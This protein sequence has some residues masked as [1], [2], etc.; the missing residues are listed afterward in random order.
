MNVTFAS[1]DEYKRKTI[2]EKLIQLIDSPIDISPIVIDGNWG[3]GKTEFSLKLQN[4][5]SDEH[6]QK[7]VIYI[8]AFKEDHCEDPLLSVTAAIANALPKKKQDALIKKAI[9]ALKFT[10]TTALKAG[11]NWVLK[12]ETETLAEDFQKAL[13]DTSNAAVD[14]AMEAL[15]KGHME[16]EKNISALKEKIRELAA[17]SQIIIIVDELDRCR[18]DFSIDMLEKI[19]HIFDIENVVFILITNLNQLKAAVNHIYGQSVNSQ[20]YLDKFIKYT[21]ALPETVKDY[22]NNFVHTSLAHWD[23]LAKNSLEVTESCML[24]KSQIEELLCIRPLSLRETET[25]FRYFSI[26]QKISEEKINKQKLYIWNLTALAAIYMYCFGDKSAIQNFPS[27]ASVQSLAKTMRIESIFSDE[28][29]IH[30]IPH[31]VFAFYGLCTQTEGIP[32]QWL[33][34]NEKYIPDLNLHLES[35]TERSLFRY[36]FIR[37]IKNTFSAFSLI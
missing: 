1:R 37:T 36:S 27:K 35:L 20:A 16:S 24:M 18:P 14:G 2:A 12:Q 4:L 25:F 30:N 29:E 31:F 6:P 8:D 11:I 17:E 34:I 9:P 33:G 21:L 7:K 3:T 22:T 15:I 13:Q 32:L 10:G 26:F 28:M 19:K 23:G 5:I